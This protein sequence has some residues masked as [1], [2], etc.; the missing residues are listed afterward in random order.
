MGQST[1]EQ[2]VLGGNE[3]GLFNVVICIIHMMYAAALEHSYS[4]S[5]PNMGVPLDASKLDD[6][7]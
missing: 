7:N 2:E 4:C 5:I 6:R 3:V 1:S